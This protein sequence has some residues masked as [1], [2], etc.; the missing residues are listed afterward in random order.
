MERRLGMLDPVLQ[1]LHQAKETATWVAQLMRVDPDLMLPAALPLLAA[2]L[3]D[4]GG[5]DDDAELA[6]LDPSAD[7]AAG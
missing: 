1:H 5:C 2:R 3:M 6:P 7:L 4:A